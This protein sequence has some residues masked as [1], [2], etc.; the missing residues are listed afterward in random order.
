MLADYS[1]YWQKVIHMWTQN[2]LA[3]K[4]VGKQM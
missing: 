2:R 3:L 1:E 4:R